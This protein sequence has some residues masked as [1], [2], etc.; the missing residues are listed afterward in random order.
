MGFIRI[1]Y[2]PPYATNNAHMFYIVCRNAEDRQNLIE[3]L[4]EN[5]VNAVF[6]YL[7]LHKSPFYAQK[8]TGGPLVNSDHYSDCL[9][10]LPMFYELTEEDVSRIYGLI[11]S[12]YKI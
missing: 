10:R 4:K 8:Y 3:Y 6:H 9:I 12:F 2:I 1:P 7:S 11:K 5:K